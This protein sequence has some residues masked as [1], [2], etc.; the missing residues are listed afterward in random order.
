MICGFMF[1]LSF[2]PYNQSVISP[3][4]RVWGVNFHRVLN[5]WNKQNIYELSNNT[6]YGPHTSLLSRHNLSGGYWTGS[7]ISYP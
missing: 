2:D 5:Y 6:A 1:P 3:H 7:F 4:M